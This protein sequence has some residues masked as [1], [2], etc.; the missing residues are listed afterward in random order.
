MRHPSDMH[1]K[2]A[3]RNRALALT[4]LALALLLAAVAFVKVSGA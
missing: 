1:A 3:P 2:M 4:L